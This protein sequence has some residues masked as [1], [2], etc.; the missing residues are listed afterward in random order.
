MLQAAACVR[1]LT[2]LNWRPGLVECGV[3]LG[4]TRA[5][6]RE[7]AVLDGAAERRPIP[8][9]RAYAADARA[10]LTHGE[11]YEP[12]FEQALALHVRAEGASCGRGHSSAY[13]E[14]LRR[15]RRRR[16]ARPLPQAVV[17]FDELPVEPWAERA[18]QGPGN[19]RDL[20]RGR[21]DDA[22]DGL[23]PIEL[24]IGGSIRQG[25]SNREIAVSLFVSPKTVEKNTSR[26]STES[27]GS[28]TPR[29]LGRS[30][31]NLVTGSDVGLGPHR[32]H[33]QLL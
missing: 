24:Q 16:R 5:A 12:L 18:R 25:N 13:G 3:K 17:L 11:G 19:R 6:A 15:E 10:R 32:D 20:V 28:V 29:P 21:T 22:R 4:E 27:W 8:T 1:T 30:A 14:R 7:A 31:L 23:T 33:Q 2:F 26:A 9:L